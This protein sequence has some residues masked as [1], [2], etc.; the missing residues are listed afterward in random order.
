[1][2][3]I[4]KKKQFDI[5]SLIENNLLEKSMSTQL[6]NP[7]DSGRGSKQFKSKKGKDRS[8]AIPHEYYY[9]AYRI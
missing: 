5:N 6:Q 9:L 2:D 8:K 3:S 7:Y 4:R 1:M